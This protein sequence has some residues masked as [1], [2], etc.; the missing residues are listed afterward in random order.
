MGWDAAE[1]AGGGITIRAAVGLAFAAAFAAGGPTPF[2]LATATEEL[3]VFEYYPH[4]AAFL[5]GGFIFPLIKLEPTLH[6]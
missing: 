1:R 3:K 5:T 4:P 6:E 2:T